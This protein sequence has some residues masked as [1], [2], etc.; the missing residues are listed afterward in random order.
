MTNNWYLK[1]FLRRL[2]AKQCP[3]NLGW[4]AETAKRD[5][6]YTFVLINSLRN[7]VVLGM[8]DNCVYGKSYCRDRFSAEASIPLRW[9]NPRDFRI[10]HHYLY[11]TMQ[12]MGFSSYVLRGFTRIDVLRA[13]IVNRWRAIDQ[14]FF[15]RRRLV[16]KQRHELLRHLVAKYAD[17]ENSGFDLIDIMTDLY[18]LKWLQHPKGNTIEKQVELYLE[19]LVASEELYKAGTEYVVTGKAITTLEQYEIEEGRHKDNIRN[20]RRLIIL[21]IVL[22]LSALIQANVIKLPTI[23]DFTRWHFY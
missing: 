22:A 18:S 19:S 3:S 2:L 15:N 12:Y 11:W 17:S 5:C 13:N 10:D 6:Y 14:F 1:F 7:F 20:Q 16:T 4:D 21:T 9:I 23:L 8:D